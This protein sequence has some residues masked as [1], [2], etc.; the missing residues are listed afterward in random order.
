MKRVFRD[1]FNGILGGVCSGLGEY[2]EIDPIDEDTSLSLTVDDLLLGFT[3]LDTGDNLFI[4]SLTPYLA[5]SNGDATDVLAGSILPVLDNDGQIVSYEF[6]P[7]DDVNGSVYLQYTVS[8]GNGP[9]VKTHLGFT[10][11]EIQDIP[12]LGKLEGTGLFLQSIDEDTTLDITV[13]DLLQSYGSP[14]D[15]T[16]DTGISF[17]NNILSGSLQGGGTDYTLDDASITEVAA[18]GTQSTLTS[19]PGFSISTDGTLELSLADSDYDELTQGQS[20]QISGTYN[21]LVDG[22]LSSEQFTITISIPFY[23]FTDTGIEVPKPNK[24]IVTLIPMLRWIQCIHEL[25]NSVA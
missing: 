9:G 25:C 3:D 13:S 12:K 21:Y 15:Y 10:I 7:F 11:N 24:E 6:T 1:S 20:V 8:D 5:D 16:V 18:D 23:S 17:A 19:I 22:E 4:E 2:F 14:D